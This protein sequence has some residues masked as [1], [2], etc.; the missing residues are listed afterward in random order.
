MRTSYIIS[1]LPGGMLQLYVKRSPSDR[2][3]KAT[4]AGK[5]LV[6]TVMTPV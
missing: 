4:A 3:P 6:M 2:S 1:T 5:G